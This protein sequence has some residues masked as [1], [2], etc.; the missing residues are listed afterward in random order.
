MAWDIAKWNV[1]KFKIFIKEI[2]N[3]SVFFNFYNT[4]TISINFFKSLNVFE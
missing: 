1:A 4:A 3:L 2:F